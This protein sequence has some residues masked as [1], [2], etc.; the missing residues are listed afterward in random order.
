MASGQR[1]YLLVDVDVMDLIDELATGAVTDGRGLTLGDLTGHRH[2]RYVTVYRAL[3]LLAGMARRGWL[4]GHDVIKPIGAEVQDKK[5]MDAF[6]A[7]HLLPCDLKI[8]AAE[9]VHEQFVS[10]IIRGNVKVQVFGRTNVVH[11][12][13]NYADRRCEANGWIDAFVQAARD[14]ARG[15]EADAVFD[16]AVVPAFARA[17]TVSRNK[18]VD[19]LNQAERQ[20]MGKPV[21]LAGNGQPARPRAQDFRVSDKLKDPRVRAAN[22]EAV[23]QVF[24]EYRR[25]PGGLSPR[26]LAQART[27]SENWVELERAWRAKWGS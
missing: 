24:D 1:Q 2:D 23:L 5:A 9:G 27:E 17:V 4:R 11:R 18:L 16:R 20:A 6:Q 14:L 19:A 15:A 25:G 22:K 12:L 21:L 10:P 8:N 26:T 3:H 13:V 7:A